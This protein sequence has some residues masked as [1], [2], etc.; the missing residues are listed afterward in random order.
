MNKRYVLAGVVIAALVGGYVGAKTYATKEARNRIDSALADYSTLVDVTYGDVDVS[1][2]FLNTSIRKVDIRPIKASESITIDEVEIVELDVKHR[3]P[4]RLHVRL[5]GLNLPRG[6]AQMLDS[7]SFGA[8]AEGGTK[9]LLG[10]FELQWKLDKKDLRFSFAA[11]VNELFSA[12]LSAS[13]GNFSF[14]FDEQMRWDVLLRS[15]LALG[16]T[17][18]RE[19]SINFADDSLFDRMLVAEAKKAKMNI[20]MLG[21]KLLADVDA[22]LAKT[23]SERERK[24]MLAFQ[25]FLVKGGALTLTATPKQ[26]VPISKIIRLLGD[27]QMNE[28]SDA[29]QLTLEQ[30]TGPSFPR[31]S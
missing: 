18:V 16:N 7:N 21:A 8:I 24:N 12:E 14:T 15:F 22:E 25:D 17:I 10:N 13:L 4:E 5:R 29:L 31:F 2:P 28:V 20:N 30:R 3:L 26:G 23:K 9:D 11:D 27:N 19:V 1:I 6:T